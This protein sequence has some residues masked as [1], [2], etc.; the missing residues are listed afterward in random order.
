MRIWGCKGVCEAGAIFSSQV[1]CSFFHQQKR[2]L[3][4][5]TL[6]AFTSQSSPLKTQPRNGAKQITLHFYRPFGSLLRLESSLRPT[7]LGERPHLYTEWLIISRAISPMMLLS[8]M[9]RVLLS[10]SMCA[11]PLT[12]ESMWDPAEWT[13]Q[14]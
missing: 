5:F 11:A 12:D 13:L 4:K 6:K 7:C 2:P 3:E 14:P 9:S 1:L 8:G 10:Q